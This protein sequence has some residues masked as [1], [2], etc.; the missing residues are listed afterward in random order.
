MLCCL[1]LSWWQNPRTMPRNAS[2]WNRRPTCIVQQSMRTLLRF[3]VLVLVVSGCGDPGSVTSNFQPITATIDQTL[4][5]DSAARI[6]PGFSIGVWSVEASGTVRTLSRQILV[7]DESAERIELV[8]NFADGAVTLVDAY[9][10]RLDADRPAE[11]QT[12]NVASIVL[13]SSS[14]DGIISGILELADRP[15]FDFWVDADP[16]S[17]IEAEIDVPFEM[18][19]G[20]VIDEFSFAVRYVGVTEDSRCPPDVTCVW[21]GQVSVEFEYVDED[22]RSVVTTTGIATPNGPA[23]GVSPT[24]DFFGSRYLEILAV[25]DQSVLVVVRTIEG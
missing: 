19:P 21:E 9:R 15:S 22:R 24:I 17:V 5:V 6:E 7:G 20:Y 18:K 14:A 12:L 25:T 13:N 11:R 8:L 2:G 16:A 23:Y 4:A 1:D 3:L 10:L